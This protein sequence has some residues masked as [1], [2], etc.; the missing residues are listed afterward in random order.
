MAPLETEGS[1][2][3]A[4]QATGAGLGQNVC[5]MSQT[6]GELQVDHFVVIATHEMYSI[7]RSSFPSMPEIRSSY[8]TLELDQI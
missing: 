5:D 3:R 8:I 2:F 4:Q 6:N 7:N 1:E